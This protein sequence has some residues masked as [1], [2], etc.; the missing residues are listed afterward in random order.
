VANDLWTAHEFLFLL[1]GKE[2]IS[3][4]DLGRGKYSGYGQRLFGD[5]HEKKQFSVPFLK[6]YR[7]V[8][9]QLDNSMR[10]G[11]LQAADCLHD[12]FRPAEL[13]RW[14]ELKGYPVPEPLQPLL[15]T[16]SARD[17]NPRVRESSEDLSDREEGTVLKILAAL[18]E[19][20]YGP[21][22]VEDVAVQPPKKSARFGIVLDDVNKYFEMSDPTLRKYLK[23]LPRIR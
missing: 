14:A 15:A 8:M 16:V 2:P 12:K 18:I 13:L 21:G 5:E 7:D 20:R 6:F 3:L 4:K 19:V 22:T 17:P 11:T 23:K 10:A 1:L 9:E